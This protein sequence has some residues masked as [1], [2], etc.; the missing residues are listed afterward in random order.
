MRSLQGALIVKDINFA[1]V[2]DITP[3]SSPEDDAEV[4]IHSLVR[5]FD[6]IKLIHLF[7]TQHEKFSLF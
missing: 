6:V 1:T 3:I 5:T 4:K 2:S 7:T